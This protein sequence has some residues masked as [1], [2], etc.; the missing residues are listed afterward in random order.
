MFLLL[1]KKG[2]DNNKRDFSDGCYMVLVESKDFN[3][4]TDNKPFFDQSLESK[5]EGY[6]KPVELSKNDDCTTG[7]LVDYLA[8][9]YY[10]KLF[11]R[12]G[13]NLSLQASKSINQQISFTEKSEEY[14]RDTI[15]FIAEKQQK[16]FQTFF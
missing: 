10:Y 6:E 13:I 16:Q 1:F 15:F 7:N 12:I 14:D 2:D 11:E 4:L 8:H 5:Q 9:Q 3:A